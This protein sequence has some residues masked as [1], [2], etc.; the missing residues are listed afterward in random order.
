MF[1]NE[2]R[3]EC[4]AKHITKLS[5]AEFEEVLECGGCP[6]CGADLADV[7]PGTFEV[8]CINCTWSEENDWHTI[9][10]WLD[11]GCPRCG[12][13]LEQYSPLH[14]VG[15]FYHKIA[16][17]DE[18]ARKIPATKLQR[19]TRP[20][21]WEIVI[22]FCKLVEFVSILKN[23]TI[24]AN[25]TGYYGVPAVCFTE[26][27]LI[28]CGEIRRTHGDYGIAFRKSEVI[29][30]GGNPALYLQ[31]DLIKSQSRHGGFADEVKPFVNLLRIPAT[32]PPFKRKKKVDF[33]HEREWRMPGHVSLNAVLPVGLVF[34]H[35][36]TSQKFMGAYGDNLIEYAYK[37][38]EIVHE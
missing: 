33:L 34:P 23:G 17:Y 30:H 9:S 25:P 24:N 7:D 4:K 38:D 12:P 13:E 14:I 3:V 37:Y 27:P 18:Y 6:K 10:A 8:E 22:H 5:L 36:S 20:D 32:A 31:D 35:I 26:T 29:K 28:L 16:H 19:A 2:V 15:S 11:Q 1:T 21:Y